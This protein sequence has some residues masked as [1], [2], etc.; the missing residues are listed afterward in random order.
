MGSIS[1]EAN[2]SKRLWF[3]DPEHGKR[4]IRLGQKVDD[5]TAKTILRH[6]D[7]VLSAKIGGESVRPETALWLRN[8]ADCLHDK[9]SK[10]GL[11]RARQRTTL[12]QFLDGFLEVRKEKMAESTAMNMKVA[13]GLL[14]KFFGPDRNMETITE[15][16]A[17]NWAADI[18][19]KYADYTCGRLVRRARQFWKSALKA[20]LVA[21]NVF[22]SVKA[23]GK[24]DES[25]QF[26][27]RPEVIRRVI[28]AA[29]N[30]E[31]RLIIALSRFGG[32]R[33]PSEHLALRW[34]DI[35]W[36]RGRFIVAS[37]K[38]GNRQVPIFKELRPYLEECFELAGEGAQFVITRY[39]D[40]SCN[41]RTTFLKIIQR[42]G[43]K[44]WPKLFHNLR[45]SRQTELSQ[46]FPLHVV[47]HWL[48]NSAP[49]AAKHYLTILD[50][51]YARAAGGDKSGDDSG[52]RSAVQGSAGKCDN[53]QNVEEN[54]DFCGVMP[55]VAD[56]GG[57]VRSVKAPRLGGER[58]RNPSGN[59]A[60]SN[61]VVTDP[62][63]EVVE[64]W[65]R[66]SPQQKAAILAIAR[67][68][69]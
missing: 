33:C 50:A 43:E 32:L 54:L 15:V 22:L 35:D 8:I 47:C 20:K 11:V 2:G 51:N 19:A 17:E 44:P 45:A 38:T 61:L 55:V 68:G 52:D 13:A 4:S 28:D 59:S 69:L 7:A 66:L 9:L 41:L 56:G 46:E 36:A 5:R 49:V 39:R 25:R 67:N 62:V 12:G 16:D 14:T 1:V 24:V 27:I 34:S 63:A 23:S 21:E 65:P 48:G 3:V 31:W 26:H 64:A 42:A 37:P 6:V 10:A 18:Q 29:P 58:T 60:I 30:A 40:P 53:L 57:K